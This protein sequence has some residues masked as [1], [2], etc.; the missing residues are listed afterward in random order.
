[1]IRAVVL[2][3]LLLMSC[4]SSERVIT[5]NGTVYNIDGNEIKR[6][7]VTVTDE[8]SDE[9]KDNVYDLLEQKENFDKANAEKIKYLEDAIEKQKDIEN[10]AKQKQKDLKEKLEALK[11]TIEKRQEARDKYASLKKEFE[12][13]KRL[14]EK[15][16]DKLSQ[17]EIKEKQRE[18]EAL[19]IKVSRAKDELEK[20]SFL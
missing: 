3:F 12:Q 5:K 7:G 18:I 13:N 16:K 15:Q 4:G 9:S 2:L 17:K 19:K 6:N 1:M 8:I 11:D 14:L 20:L 10:Q